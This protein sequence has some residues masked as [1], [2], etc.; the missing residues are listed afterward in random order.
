VS[1]A[2]N[3]PTRGS[4]ERRVIPGAHPQRVRVER[5]ADGRPVLS[6]YC[7]LFR[8]ESLLLGGTFVETLEPGCFAESLRRGDDVRFLWEHA[9]RDLL[10]RT[11]NGTLKLREDSVGLLFI[12][13]PAPTSAG[14]DVV[15][16]VERGDLHQCSFAFIAH[17]D[18][19]VQRP[20]R[21][22]LRRV[23]AATLLDCTLTCFPAY[24]ATSVDVVDAADAEWLTEA[25]ARQRRLD[26]LAEDA[27]WKLEAEARERRLRLLAR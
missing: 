20:G 6:G 10:A 24:V 5:R 7:A 3:T 25:L 12:A 16:L 22:P 14:R 19:V 23:K 8:S 11:T 15:A 26:A 21:P 13:D 2:E 17:D 9:S 1:T 18:D 27:E 4:V